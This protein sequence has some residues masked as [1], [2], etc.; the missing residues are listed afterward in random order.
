MVSHQ[1]HQ[2]LRVPEVIGII[3]KFKSKYEIE[4]KEFELEKTVAFNL[5]QKKMN[6][7]Q[8]LNWDYEILIF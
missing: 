2:F 3:E 8:E 5:P 4:V 6:E 7:I 1:E